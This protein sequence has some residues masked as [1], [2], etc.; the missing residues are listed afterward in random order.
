MSHCIVWAAILFPD[1][2]L[3][4]DNSPHVCLHFKVPTL[5]LAVKGEVYGRRVS[6]DIVV[7][8]QDRVLRY[9]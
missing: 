1:H 7:M 5:H 4:S 2:Y 3:P 6:L 8:Y 9:Q